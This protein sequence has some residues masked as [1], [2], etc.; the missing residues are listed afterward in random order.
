MQIAQRKV[1]ENTNSKQLAPNK[2]AQAWSAEENEII[3]S[4][5]FEMLMAELRGDKFSKTGHRNIILAHLPRRGKGSIEYKH[6]NISAV[7]AEMGLPFIDGYKPAYNFQKSILVRTVE[8]YVRKHESIETLFL[9]FSDTP[10][11]QLLMPDF[12]SWVVNAPKKREEQQQINLIRKPLHINYLKREQE[13][14]LLGIQGEQL[15]FEYEKS[16]LINK[17]KDS[18][19]KK[20]EWISRDQGDGMGFDILSKNLNGTDK[21]VEV[22]T[23]KMGKDS[24]FYFTVNEYNFSIEKGTDFHL[25]RVFDMNKEPRLFTLNGQFDTF[26]RIEPTHYIGRF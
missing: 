25:Y 13:N 20:V 24:P 1:S 6:Q 2:S 4:D 10:A 8:E 9:G 12:S 23:T 19:A 26:C 3:V 15:V 14:R 18:L 21:Y 22:K 17:G 5:Y 7:L 11:R 16:I